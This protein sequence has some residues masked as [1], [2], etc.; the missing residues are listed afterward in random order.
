[1][2]ELAEL[3]NPIQLREL[4]PVRL[5]EQSLRQRIADLG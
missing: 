5:A 2:E 1:L 4:P 3:V